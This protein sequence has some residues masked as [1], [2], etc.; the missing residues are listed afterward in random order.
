MHNTHYNKT[1]LF[2]KYAL[3]K[4]IELK[5][6]CSTDISLSHNLLFC[7]GY[8]QVQLFNI[9]G[10]LWRKLINCRR[11]EQFTSSHHLNPVSSLARCFVDFKSAFYCRLGASMAESTENITIT[12]VMSSDCCLIWVKISEIK[13]Y[14]RHELYCKTIS[15]KQPAMQQNNNGYQSNYTKD[16]F[17]EK[18]P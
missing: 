6:E 17:F 10:I 7:N 5:T 8:L 11:D 9:I 2:I 14:K 16:C 15:I 18:T 13:S 4:N 1:Q 12:N 3:L